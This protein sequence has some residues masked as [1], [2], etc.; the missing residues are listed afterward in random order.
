MSKV[1]Q[2]AVQKR[3]RLSFETVVALKGFGSTSAYE[4]NYTCRFEKDGKHFMTYASPIQ[5]DVG[6][7]KSENT[8]SVADATHDDEDV[9][10]SGEVR[11]I[12]EKQEKIEKLNAGL[13]DVKS[14]GIELR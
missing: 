1:I 7:I 14:T 3:F 11:S 12:I 10:G 2:N 6:D 9:T 8:L 5:Y 4:G 13:K